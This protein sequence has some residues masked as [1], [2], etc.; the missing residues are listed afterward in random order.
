[1]VLLTLLFTACSLQQTISDTPLPANLPGPTDTS[2]PARAT[3]APPTVPAE[4]ADLIFYNGSVI[5]IER[6]Q[7]LAQ[8]VAI[9]A[10]LIQAVGTN[11]EILALQGPGTA[12]VDL[13]GKTLMPGFIEAHSHFII[14][15][16]EDG[17]P[18]EE[19]MDTLLS[20]GLTG[21]SELRG[22][23]NFIEAMLQAERDGQLRVRV[24]VFAEYNYG[25]LENGRTIVD[26]AWHL[27]HGPILEPGRMLRIPG[28]K[29]F[30][31]GAAV[32]KRGCPY[33]S[34][35]IPDEAYAL[36]EAYGLDL[37]DIC[38][39]TRGDLYLTQAQLIEAIQGIQDRG[40]RAAFH[41][42][43]DAAVDAILNALEVVL[44]GE[45]NAKYRHQI[46]HN[47]G[48]RPDQVERYVQ[49]DIIASVRSMFNTC[50]ADEYV[51]LFGEGR[52]EWAI[53]RFQLP[54]LDLHVI[55]EG[56]LGRGDVND[57][58]RSNQLNPIFKL[59]GMVTHQQLRK[60]GSV[61]RP[62]D[63]LAQYPI[64]VERAL[65][66]LTIESAY[67]VS[68]EEYVGSIKPGKYADLVILSGNP[69]TTTP[70]NLINLQVRMT[71]VNGKVEY[72]AAEYEPLCKDQMSSQA[73]LLPKGFHDA[74]EGEQGRPGCWAHGWA[75]DPDDRN[76]DLKIRVL[77]DGAEVAQT[78]ASNSR[79][80]LED[81]GECPGGTC[82]FSVD[83]W[84]LI[85][86]NTDHSVLVEAQDAQT[87]EWVSLSETP[88]TLNCTGP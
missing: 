77:V 54:L 35:P 72:C 74:N 66:M 67:A 7:P 80:D 11:E 43:G 55:A 34:F 29:I 21:V 87:A 70:D 39:S 6:G 18:F 30:A 51:A 78:T 20:F 42:M 85:S 47:S 14:N 3:T 37:S 46:H 71:M 44:K 25:I 84:G 60:D 27:D 53:N 75:A 23:R 86:H 79:Q 15:S 2:T 32:P 73:N 58:T 59:Y 62:P 83:L 63:W 16:V 1:M 65:E 68:M 52:Y 4:P 82:A 9:R 17:V 41:A 36:Y 45:P 10:G 38:G 40:S 61:C 8:A 28:V 22:N 81:V 48:L 13:Q 33:Y 49:M 31:D 76:L 88:K 57:R 5:T 69:L 26:P 56:D 19:I 24:N 64:S 50:E 12:K